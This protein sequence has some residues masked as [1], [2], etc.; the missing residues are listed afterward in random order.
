MLVGAAITGAGHREFDHSRRLKAEGRLVQARVVDHHESYRLRSGRTCRLD[1]VFPTDKQQSVTKRLRVSRAV[2]QTA[3]RQGT[4]PVHYLPGEPTICTA[5]PEVEREFFTLALGLGIVV[6]GGVLAFTRSP[7]HSAAQATADQIAR[8]CLAEYEYRPADPRRFRAVDHRFYEEGRRL[9][10]WHGYV[11]LGDQENVTLNRQSNGAPT[12]LRL[13]VSREGT[14]MSALYHFRPN[15]IWRLLGAR[16]AR[17]LDLETQFTDGRWL[18]TCNAE[19]AGQLE[20]PPGIDAAH[21][22]DRTPLEAVVQA[23]ETRLADFLRRHP[24]ASPVVVRSLEDVQRAQATLQRLKAEHRRR[25]GLTK[26]ELRRL[27]GTC[28]RDGDRL[29]AEIQREHA[30]RQAK[31]A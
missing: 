2:Y 12:F 5:G 16:E 21:L 11:P 6:A 7:T 4:V 23:H 9:L 10:E 8:L 3:L 31:A 14:T 28:G 25:I 1:V 22:P 13:H 27:G 19:A 20:S 15:W 24:G 29:H 18:V 30:A 17:V 26:E